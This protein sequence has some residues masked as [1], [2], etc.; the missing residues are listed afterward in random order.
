MDRKISACAIVAGSLLASAASADMVKLADSR[1]EFS[2]TQGADGWSYGWYAGEDIAAA[3]GFAA[4]N[5]AGFQTFSYY[6]SGTGW[7]THDA[8]S[9]SSGSGGSPFF[10]TVVT[11]EAMHANAPIPGS[12]E[13]GDSIRWASRRWTSE[14][15]G[16]ID[17]L[18]HVAKA[19]QGSLLGD[20]ADAYIV[21]DGISVYH[22]GVEVGDYEGASF[23]LSVAVSEGSTVEFIVGA[24]ESGLFDAVNFRSEIYGAP[25]PTPGALAL[26]GAGGLLAGRRRR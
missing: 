26:L 22:Y 20:G 5:T 1:L 14:I 13:V 9:A 2:G 11:E 21:V 6:A 17:I 12:Q 25:V 16:T 8:A 10:L 18:G 23:N 4:V 24:R 7:W 19:D 15:S 3:P